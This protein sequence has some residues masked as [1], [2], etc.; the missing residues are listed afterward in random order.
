MTPERGPAT[1]AVVTGSMP[2]LAGDHGPLQHHFDDMEQQNESAA[3]GMWLFLLTELMFFGGVFTAYAVYRYLFNAAFAE[4]ASHLD[5]QLGT[6]NTVILIFSSLTMALAVHAAQVG[7]KQLIVLFLILTMVFGG[8]F[9]V[10]KG[11]EYSHKWHEHHV[12]GAYF[13]YD[14]P[15]ANQVHLFFSFY[16]TMTG[17]HALHM[18]LGIGWMAWLTRRALRGDFG[19]EYNS[20]VEMTGLYWHFVDIVWIFLFPLLYLFGAGAGGH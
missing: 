17:I 2:E 18:V 8:A 13:E 15:L 11:I 1:A 6:I 19:P 12:P 9:L 20:P 5:V 3:L 14:G 16:F 10:I 4:G 7:R